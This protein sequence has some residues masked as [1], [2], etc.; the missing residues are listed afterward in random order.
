MNPTWLYVAIVYAAVFQSW[1]RA[2]WWLGA[3]IGLVQGLFL[4]TAVMPLLPSIHPRM[5][6]EQWGPTPTKQLEPP[7]FMGMHYGRRTPISVLIAHVAYG[8][9]QG[10]FYHLA[11]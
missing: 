10:A 8:A 3:S 9:I 1:G 4:L 6:S 7:G 5:A 11:Q 2:T